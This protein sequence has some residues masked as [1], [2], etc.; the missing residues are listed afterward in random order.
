MRSLKGNP[1]RVMIQYDVTV[2]TGVNLCDPD[3]NV[4]VGDNA[5]IITFE[6]TFCQSITQ[7]INFTFTRTLTNV[8]TF[9][10]MFTKTYLHSQERSR[11]RSQERFDERIYVQENVCMNV[12]MNVFTFMRTFSRTYLRSQERLREQ[13]RTST[14]TL[15]MQAVTCYL[16][17][18]RT[19]RMVMK[20]Y[21]V[22]V[23]F[24]LEKQF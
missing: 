9:T 5:N 11:E 2:S 21:C 17:D 13:E 12:C 8:F 10:R 16:F 23:P 4:H 20:A 7:R 1:Q 6:G 22:T 24:S 15:L 19:Q 14:G 3:W 18:A